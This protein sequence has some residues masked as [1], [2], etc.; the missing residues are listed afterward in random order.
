MKSGA[1][2]SGAA[3]LLLGC[4][5]TAA[6]DDGLGFAERQARI[7]AVDDW[8]LGGQ[9]II[10][11]GER[12]DRM[13]IVW[14]QQGERLRLTVRGLV[15]GAGSVRIEGDAGRLVIEA[16]GEARV[17]DDPEVGLMEELGWW[18][19]VTSLEHWLL[20]LP[21]P[22]FPART[23]YGPAGAVE[24]LRQ[25]DWRIDYEE[26][27]LAGGLLVPRSLRLTHQALDLRLSGISWTP[28]AADAP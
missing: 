18:L 10:D 22:G 14:E 5:H 11:T 6:I 21:D 20:G 15:I 19:P 26:Y 28:A 7:E 16:R 4:V 2:L 8:S 17:L 9:L 24:T 1:A 25:R 27:Q 23:D 13:R 12:R 3:L